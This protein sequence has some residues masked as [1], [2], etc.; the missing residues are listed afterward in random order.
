MPARSRNEEE[1][2]VFRRALQVLA[3]TVASATAV[4]A[5]SGGGNGGSGGSSPKTVAGSSSAVQ[6]KT[7]T[8]GLL[9]DATGAGA[10]GNKTSVQGLEA[11]IVAAQRAGYKIKYIL[12]DTQTNPGAVLTSAKKLVQQNHVDAVVAISALTFAAAPYLTSQ[13]VP[14]VG[15]AEDGPE[16]R[17]S[18]NMFSVIGTPDTTLVPD[19][20]GR[21]FKQ[22]GASSVGA[23]GYGISPGSSEAAKAA[24]ASAKA[25]GLKVGY[26]NSKLQFGTTDLAPIA[27]QM[28]SSGVDGVT[29]AT[30]SNTSFALVTA[31][32]NQGHNPKAVI[33]STGY[34]GDLLEAGP[35]ARQAAQNVYFLVP[36]E[37]VEMQTAA[38]KQFQQDLQAVGVKGA[39]TF[40]EYLGYA[41]A[42]LLAQTLKSTG[43]ATDQ[44]SLMNALKGISSFD[45]GGLAGGHP[46]KIHDPSGTSSGADNCVWVARLEGSTFQTVKSALPICGKMLPGVKVSP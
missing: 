22:F 28:A 1:D 7:L 11:G 26:L 44:A 31:L 3:L 35:G 39:P 20:V 17:T 40:T 32:R 45:P 18:D 9:T 21:L 5:C 29:A 24:A 38:T 46:V 42:L 41:S 6:K 8:V 14:V 27:Q 37:P 30:D 4:A 34:G 43:G 23:I 36:F 12:A 19:F 10:S 2:A 15:A 33:L 13:H 16:W 25:A